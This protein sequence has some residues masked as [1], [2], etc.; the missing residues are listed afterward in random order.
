MQNIEMEKAVLGG[1]LI[2]TD[3]I[4]EVDP[5]LNPSDFSLERHK[6]IYK[7]IIGLNREQKPADMI[8]LCDELEKNKELE[9]VGGAT[10]LA[11]LVNSIPTSYNTIFFAKEIKNYSHKQQLLA[12]AG[13]LQTAIT[14]E[15]PDE[16]IQSIQ[17]KLLDVPR[18]GQVEPQS[19]KSLVSDYFEEYHEPIK[20]GIKTGFSTLDW[21]TMG[22]HNGDLIT[23]LAKTGVGKTNLALSF[24]LN[25][26]KQGKKVLYISLEMLA[27][28][29]IDRMIAMQGNLSAFNIRSRNIGDDKISEVL[30]YFYDKNFKLLFAPEMTS[31]EVMNQA[32][33][34]QKKHGLDLLIVDYLG[35][36]SDSKGRGSEEERITSMTRNL[37]NCA[38]KLKIPVI[39]PFQIDKYSAKN[40]SEPSVED[41]KGSTTI[42]HESDLSL[43]LKRQKDDEEK[44][45]FAELHI[46]KNRSGEGGIIKLNFNKSNLRFYEQEKILESPIQG[47]SFG[48]KP[49]SERD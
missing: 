39:T 13:E 30:D 36:L 14:N 40:D 38:L 10:Y 9:R 6:L 25:A 26:I 5:I 48:S 8:T 7:T 42:G 19:I 18:G 31:L 3:L 37:K 29:L 23:I 2:T 41:A 12:V 44:E 15:E 1:L 49:Y 34:E 27:N 28:Q 46:V 21:R 43:Y 4:Y 20:F 32:F 45:E 22:F 33:I 47:S 24:A 17:E 16:K 11:N 35:R